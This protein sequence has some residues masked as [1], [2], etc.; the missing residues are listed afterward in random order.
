MS[1]LFISPG[2]GRIAAEDTV[3][4]LSSLKKTG[5]LKKVSLP[6]VANTTDRNS[7]SIGLPADTERPRPV[8]I[9]EICRK[10]ILDL[11]YDDGINK[12]DE[13]LFMDLS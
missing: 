13:C 2:P 8:Y 7:E 11:V 10:C 5:S 6:T 12:S 3:G 1:D 4:W 9:V